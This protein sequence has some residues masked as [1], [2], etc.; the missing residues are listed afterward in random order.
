MASE[1]SWSLSDSDPSVVLS[2]ARAWVREKTPD[3][4][5]ADEPLREPEEKSLEL[6]PEPVNDQKRRVPGSTLLVEIL[7]LRMSPSWREEG[8]KEME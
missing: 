3:V 1:K 5:M 6:M 7:E 2:C 8:E 4:S